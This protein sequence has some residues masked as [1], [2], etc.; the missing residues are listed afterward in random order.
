MKLKI[1]IVLSLLNISNGL[2][3]QAPSQTNAQITDLGRK[4]ALFIQ[5][6]HM[7]NKPCVLRG[8][9][10]A[11]A[12]YG[13]TEVALSSVNFAAE[14]SGLLNALGIIQE[15]TLM[16]EIFQAVENSPVIESVKHPT[17]FHFGLLSAVLIFAG[18][19]YAI[20]HA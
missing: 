4:V 5:K 14:K 11:F 2:L 1:L 13:A 20:Y 18:A 17:N 8:I 19:A 6:Y 3:A 12:V 15:P 7:G 9:A 16:Q 10:G